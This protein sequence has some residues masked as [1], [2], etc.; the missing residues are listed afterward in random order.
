M[1]TLAP[2]RPDGFHWVRG[3]ISNVGAWTLTNPEGHP[4]AHVYRGNDRTWCAVEDTGT[5]IRDG[6]TTSG[7][8]FRAADTQVRPCGQ[9]G[10][11]AERADGSPYCA[12]HQEPV[13]II[14]AA[15]LGGASS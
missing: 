8:A 4:V 1:T 2:L 14:S 12:R 7:E 5:V 11:D 10:C 9:N 13:V 3:L 6:L 15:N